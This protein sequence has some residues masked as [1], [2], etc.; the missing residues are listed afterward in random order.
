MPYN[1]PPLFA[2][3]PAIITEMDPIFSSHEFIRRLMWRHQ[4]LFVE[5]LD[6]Y[7]AD[8]PFRKVH[9][10]ISK[11]LYE[12]PTLITYIGHR[13]SPNVFGEI[14]GCA[15]WRKAGTATVAPPEEFDLGDD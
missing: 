6:Y 12:Y 2:H 8:Q 15:F 7:G 4:S 9:A 5:A 3:I 14:Q 13:P 1:Y 11:E 10:R